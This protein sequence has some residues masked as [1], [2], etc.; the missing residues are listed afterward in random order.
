MLGKWIEE[1]Q[2]KYYEKFI[3]SVKD[4]AWIIQLNGKN[5][6]LVLR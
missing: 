2:L 5:I 4:D 1:D 6:G 3:E